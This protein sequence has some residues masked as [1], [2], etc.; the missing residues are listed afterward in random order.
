MKNLLV[1]LCILIPISLSAQSGSKDGS[2]NA[3]KIDQLQIIVDAGM[4]INITGSNTDKITYTYD[5]DGNDE[6]YNHRFLNFDPTFTS[7]SGNGLLKIE[8]PEH[9]KKNVNYRIKKNILTLNIPR[10]IELRLDTRY[11]KV[12]I[13]SIARTTNI[14]NRSGSVKLRNIGQSATIDNDYGDI[15]AEFVNGDLTCSSRSSR[16]DVKNIQGNFKASS[17]YS[18]INVTKVTGQITIENKSGTINAFDLDSDFYSNGDYSDYE[19]T[20]IRGEI[21]IMSKNGTVKIDK[22]ESISIG[23]DYTDVTGINLRG[24]D[25]QIQGKSAK[26]ELDNVLGRV[27]IDGSYLD[28]ELT[29]IEK[30]VYITNRSG[31]INAEM[32]KGSFQM[33]GDYNKIKLNKFLGDKIDIQNRSGNIDIDSESKLTQMI[34]DAS[35]TDV[36]VNLESPFN[37][38]VY[39]DVTYGK[40]EQPFKLNNATFTNENNSKIVE[41]SVGNENSVFRIKSRNGDVKVTQN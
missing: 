16:I 23:G 15:D 30:E 28:I 40:L 35:Y 31:K 9:K 4:T 26:V 22:A 17:N 38:S 29:N 36:Q 20:D 25:V 13:N 11:S 33:Y 14:T 34:I 27:R 39:F 19:L 37:G 2:F 6:A 18:K 32:I 21:Q 41:G 5:F 3:S 1:L 8:F 24:D 10:E 12:Q 7:N